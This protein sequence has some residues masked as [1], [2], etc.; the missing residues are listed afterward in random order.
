MPEYAK[1]SLGS[2]AAEGY[3][4]VI[5]KRNYDQAVKKDYETELDDEMGD[6]NI[7]ADTINEQTRKDYLDL[8]I[9]NKKHKLNSLFQAR[10]NN[11]ISNLRFRKRKS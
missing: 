2:A 8:S 10:A 9:G 6:L 3:N 11:E 4:L 1:G 5:D 7:E